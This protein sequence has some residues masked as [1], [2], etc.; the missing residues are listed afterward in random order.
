LK[1][2]YEDVAALAVRLGRPLEDVAF[3][4]RRRARLIVGESA[5]DDLYPNKEQ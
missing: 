5:G 4:V 1:P 3:D 2:E